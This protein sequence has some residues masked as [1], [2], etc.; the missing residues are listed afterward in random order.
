MAPGGGGAYRN[1]TMFVLFP[2]VEVSG[3]L[4]NGGNTQGW[5]VRRLSLLLYT[6]NIIHYF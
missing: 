6:D 5:Y 2:K 3:V 1:L 4:A